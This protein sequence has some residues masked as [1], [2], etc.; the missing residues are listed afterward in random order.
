MQVIY[1]KYMIGTILKL[2]K[3][4]QYISLNLRVN[5]IN[6]M[7][8]IFDNVRNNFY[9]KLFDKKLIVNKDKNYLNLS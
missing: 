3:Q 8:N 1:F 2:N 4:A 5:Q 9:Y 7:L 6:E